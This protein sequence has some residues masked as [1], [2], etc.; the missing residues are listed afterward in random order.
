MD[1]T[2]GDQAGS[3]GA[4]TRIMGIVHSAL[5]RDLVR[6]RG[7]LT[8]APYPVGA[9]RR[10]L[11]RHAAWLMDLLHAH[12]AAEDAGLWP[13]VL[14]A[15]PD[16]ATLLESLERDHARIDPAAT[17]FA[18]AGRCY[19]GADDG[20]DDPSRVNL[21]DRLDALETVLLP[22]LAREEAEAMPV[23]AAAI[24]DAQWRHWDQAYNVKAR[25][26]AEVGRTGLWILDDLDEEGRSV[27]RGLVPPVPRFIL[28]SL[29]GPG[30]RRACR[31]RWP[32][33][34]SS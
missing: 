27:V 16:T 11:G 4:D 32:P 18:E 23:V 31:R 26:F 13:T 9:Q 17:S 21:L 24:S 30:Y 19:A 3:T 15:A 29:F 33:V 34:L 25:P 1:T 5:R 7:E 6:L 8:T 10:A 12:H 20:P 14:R 28:L 22:H 2:T